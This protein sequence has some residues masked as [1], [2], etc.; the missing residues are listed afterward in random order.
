MGISSE[1]IHNV[2]RTYSR[3]L[4]LG[5]R[6]RERSSTPQPSQGDRVTISARAQREKAATE[7]PLDIASRLGQEL[8]GETNGARQSLEALGKL[9]NRD[10]HFEKNRNT[11]KIGIVDGS[12]GKRVDEIELSLANGKEDDIAQRDRL[13]KALTH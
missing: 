9:Y 7:I 11:I 2:L 8:N 5:T 3:Q 6:L 10:L 13:I 4:A 12:N 1:Q